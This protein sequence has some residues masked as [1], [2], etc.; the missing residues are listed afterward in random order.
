MAFSI[1]LGGSI[2]RTRWLYHPH[3]WLNLF[4]ILRVGSLFEIVF[5][6]SIINDRLVSK[7]VYQDIFDKLN[8]SERIFPNMISLRAK[9]VRDYLSMCPTYYNVRFDFYLSSL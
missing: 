7:N 6:E 2:Y 8:I 4:A 5:C 1:A 3:R 9:E